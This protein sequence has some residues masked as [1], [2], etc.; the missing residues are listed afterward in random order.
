MEKGDSTNGIFPESSVVT[1]LEQLTDSSIS[2]ECLT[3]TFFASACEREAT[4]NGGVAWTGGGK[5][6]LVFNAEEPP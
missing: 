1:G 4:G 6:L 2:G 3:G 5:V